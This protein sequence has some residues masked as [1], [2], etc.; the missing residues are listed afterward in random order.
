MTGV[1]TC[2]LPILGKVLARLVDC[3]GRPERLRTDNGRELISAW[4]TGWCEK[5]GIALHL[6]QPGRSMQNAPIERFNVSFHCELLDVHLFHSLT[7]VRQLVDEWM[8][9][10]NTQRPQ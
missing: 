1:Q 7:Q 6:I 3:H 2:A 4:L 5:Q 8:P 9:V 10:Y